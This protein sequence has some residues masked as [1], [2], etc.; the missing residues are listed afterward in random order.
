MSKWKEW[1]AYNTT[2]VESGTEFGK[3][4]TGYNR[5]ESDYLYPQWEA[6]YGGGIGVIQ[7]TS[8]NFELLMTIKN[9]GGDMSPLAGTDLGQALNDNNAAGI[10][11]GVGSWDGGIFDKKKN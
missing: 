7:F 3:P 11:W 9:R 2:I 4:V 10:N 5:V 8:N 1:G 6:G